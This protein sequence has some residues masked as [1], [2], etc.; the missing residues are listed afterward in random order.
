MRFKVPQ[1]VSLYF[2]TAEFYILHAIT[3]YIWPMSR[4]AA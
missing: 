1:Y 4:L 2:Y 3:N